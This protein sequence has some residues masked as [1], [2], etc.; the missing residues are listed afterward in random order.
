[1]DTI[2]MCYWYGYDLSKG[3]PTCDQGH[4]ASLKCHSKQK[5]CPNYIATSEATLKISHTLHNKQLLST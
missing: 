5:N 1:M 3:K 4:K 2:E